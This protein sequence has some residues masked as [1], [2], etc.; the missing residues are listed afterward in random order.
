MGPAAW[1]HVACASPGEHGARL[2]RR[3]ADGRRALLVE[4]GGGA[5]LA[6]HLLLAEDG[7]AACQ[8]VAVFE[9]RVEAMEWQGA[10]LLLAF[11]AGSARR[12]FSVFPG[13]RLREAAGP[14]GSTAGGLRWLRVSTRRSR[15]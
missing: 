8:D 9:G 14:G 13:M 12:V 2:E 15:R 3:A 10:D 7:N 5:Q 4:A 11:A 6:S 1:L